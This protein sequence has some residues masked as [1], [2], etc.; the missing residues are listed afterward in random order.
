MMNAIARQRTSLQT[1]LQQL[2]DF[3]RNFNTTAVN[4][5]ATLDD[6]D[7]LVDAS[8]P[9]ADRLGPFFRNFRAA[10]AD[11]VPTV[12]DLDVIVEDPGKDN[13]LV[14]LTRLQ[15]PPGEDRRRPRQPQRRPAPGRPARVERRR[16]TTRS[17]SW[18][19]SAP[20]RRS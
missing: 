12:R 4:L 9:V 8:K 13:D 18:P 10:S 14:D 17:T 15:P 20:T 11:L 1:A 5:R 16:C 2:P 6:L 7:P 19:S 3:M